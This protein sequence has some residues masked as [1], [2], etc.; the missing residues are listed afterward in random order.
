MTNSDI[1]IEAFKSQ[2]IA[3]IKKSV[4]HPNRIVS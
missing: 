3:F 1:E 4:P 2:C